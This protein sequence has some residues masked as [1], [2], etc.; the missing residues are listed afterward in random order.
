MFGKIKILAAAATAVFLMETVPAAAATLTC[1]VGQVTITADNASSRDC[2]SGNLNES[3][4]VTY[5]SMTFLLGIS[6]SGNPVAGSPLSW[7]T[8][9]MDVELGAGR[10]AWGIALSSSWVGQVLL[11]LKQSNSYALFDVTDSCDF[12]LNTCSGTWTTAGPGGSLNDLSHTRAWYKTT[13]VTVV[14][15]PAAGWMLLAGL[16]GL[17][18]MRRRKNKS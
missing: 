8:D 6:D 2:A 16:G 10:L 15:L 3:S 9:P 1:T 11:E 13:G 14:P 5:G 17:A 18:A 7:T 12:L 4:P